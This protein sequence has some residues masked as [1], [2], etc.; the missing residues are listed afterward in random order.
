MDPIKF[1]STKDSWERNL[2]VAISAA[3]HDI[4]QKRDDS[5]ANKIAADIGKAMGGK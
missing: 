3:V 5:L 1:L 4:Q 2:M